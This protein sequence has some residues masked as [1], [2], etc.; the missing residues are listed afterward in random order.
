M[1]VDSFI[2]SLSNKKPPTDLSPALTALWF[3]HHE[4]W[5]KAHEAVQN[6]SDEL[7]AAIHAY[8]HRKEGDIW[9]A[10]YWYRAARRKPC[11]GPLKEEWDMLVSNACE[12]PGRSEGLAAR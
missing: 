4:E 7:S 6:E 8:L 1:T 3:D 2:D 12:R 10:N 11:N 5:E 9:N